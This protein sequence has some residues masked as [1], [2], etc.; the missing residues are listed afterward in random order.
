MPVVDTSVLLCGL[1]FPDSYSG[2]FLRAVANNQA[3][4]V[5]SNTIEEEAIRIARLKAPYLESDIRKFIHKC[6]KYIRISEQDVKDLL[7]TPEDQDDAHVVATAVVA[8]EPVIYT[9]DL[10]FFNQK[11]KRVTG[12]Y[13]IRPQFPS[14]EGYFKSPLEDVID[15]PTYKPRISSRRGTITLTLTTTWDSIE[16]AHLVNKK[17]YVLDAEGIFALWYDAPKQGFKFLPDLF[18]GKHLLFIS[19]SFHHGEHI[20]ITV[21][22]DFRKG[23]DVYVGNKE[24]HCNKKWPPVLE[25]RNINIGHSRNHNDHMNGLYSGIRVFGDY[26]SQRIVRIM[27]NFDLLSVSDKDLEIA[28]S[29]RWLLSRAKKVGIR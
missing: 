7:V 4:G 11:M 22:F 13:G 1:A 27:H 14:F 25:S 12:V 26:L 29:N 20:R 18:G 15:L 17:W 8:N 5:V 19:S 23:F 3:N 16:R 2:E 9:L 6:S 24:R 10:G 28:A 21:T